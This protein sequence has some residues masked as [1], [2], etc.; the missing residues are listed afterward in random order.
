MYLG[1]QGAAVLLIAGLFYCRSLDSAISAF[2]G[3]MAFF[4]PNAIF[5][6][7]SFQHRGARSAKQIVNSI[8]K[9][10][11]IK[12]VLTAGLFILIFSLV[13][14]LDPLGLFTAFIGTQAVSW[15]ASA[16]LTHNPKQR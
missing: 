2:L 5:A 10:E 9:A 11:V 16:K 14:M 1:A 13:D 15:L 6:M 3:G 8:Y 12:L 7:R 4:I